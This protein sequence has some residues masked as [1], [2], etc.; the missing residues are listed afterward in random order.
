MPASNVPD[1]I[2]LSVGSGIQDVVIGRVVDV[3]QCVESLLAK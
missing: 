3:E 2:S 1:G